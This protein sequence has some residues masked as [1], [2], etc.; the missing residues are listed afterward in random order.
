MNWSQLCL[1]EIVTKYI[2]ICCVIWFHGGAL[3]WH[4]L[5]Q[6]TSEHLG[7]GVLGSLVEYENVFIYL[8]T[9]LA[10]TI[11]VASIFTAQF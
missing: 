6:V 2:F 10:S 1:V 3:H 11:V 4:R 9:P 8:F 5:G 7:W